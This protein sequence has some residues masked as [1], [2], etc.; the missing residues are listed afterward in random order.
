MW[1][2]IAG[3]LQ[4]HYF[5]CDNE[6][7]N[8]CNCWWPFCC[9]MSYYFT[10]AMLLGLWKEVCLSHAVVLQHTRQQPQPAVSPICATCP[11]HL[12]LLDFITWKILGEQY[13]SLSSS[14]CSF[15]HSCYLIPLR[16]KYSPQHPI[17]KHLS[18][19]S[20]LSGSDQVSHPYKTK[21]KLQFCMS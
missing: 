9:F 12:I 21:D 7:C 15:L 4:T 19:H 20:S 5:L 3:V 13:G 14:L 11:A 1:V 8:G 2:Y 6:C 17:H 16:P 10:Y 18:L